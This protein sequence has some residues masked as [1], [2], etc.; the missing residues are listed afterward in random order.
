MPTQGDFILT[1][2]IGG[3]NTN[4][5]IFS[6]KKLLVSLHF[7]SKEIKDFVRPVQQVLQY[8]N[9]RYN[10]SISNACFAAAGPV[11]KNSYCKI[12]NL[13]WDIDTRRIL[14]NTPL[15]S[16]TI[17]NDF[18]AVA[19]GIGTIEQKYIHTMKRGE[20]LRKGTKAVIGAGTG[21]GKALLI[22][23]SKTNSYSAL[24]SEGGHID[25]PI[26]PD[27]EEELAL[28]DLIK[29]QQG[30]IPTLEDVLS[31][32]GIENIYRILSKTGRYRQKKIDVDA[33]QISKHIKNDRLCR[34][35]LTL[36]ARF[37]GRAAKNFALDTLALGGVYIAG[38]I[39]AKNKDI[40]RSEFKEEFLDNK[41]QRRVLEKIPI[42]LITNYD[43]SLYGAAVVAEK[44]LKQNR[45]PQIR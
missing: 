35:T 37:Y 19:Y 13:S 23:N 27:N 1:A 11:E 33:G 29:K 16:A 39:A 40:F 44:L 38:G 41:T 34:D 5:A 21:L 28:Y 45:L 32:E 15:G 26:H 36:F 8:V 31:G 25:L 17:I 18:L 43:I 24:P 9:D 30:A 12:T 7:D 2:D 6:K 22:W 3:T 20:V 42:F 14:K 4:F 10:I